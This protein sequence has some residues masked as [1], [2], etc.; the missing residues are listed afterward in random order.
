[1]KVYFFINQ[2][3]QVRLI[4]IYFYEIFKGA[5]LKDDP[6]VVVFGDR[7]VYNHPVDDETPN[8][9][10]EKIGFFENLTGKSRRFLNSL[11]GRNGETEREESEMGLTVRNE[12]KKAFDSIS[13]AWQ[14]NVDRLQ[15]WS[16]QLHGKN[17]TVWDSMASNLKDM[18]GDLMGIWDSSVRFVSLEN[19]TR[20][21]LEG[22]L[23]DEDR[24][25]RLKE[26]IQERSKRVTQMMS[27]V[28]SK[29]NEKDENGSISWMPKFNLSHVDDFVIDM[30][31]KMN[32]AWKKL[33][34]QMTNR[35]ANITT[36][37][38]DFMKNEVER[39]KRIQRDA[40]QMWNTLTQARL[41]NGTQPDN[42][43]MT[44]LNNLRNYYSE[45]GNG[46][47]VDGMIKSAQ[48]RVKKVGEYLKSA[49]EG[50]QDH[51]KSQ[52]DKIEQLVNGLSRSFG[53]ILER[54][55]NRRKDG[56]NTEIIQPTDSSVAKSGSE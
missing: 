34:N 46:S 14:S 39:L 1:M 47:A 42:R 36:E 26:Y 55:M 31:S 6:E 30:Q 10:E 51:V 21:P 3:L 41:E 25:E 50:S 8:R 28:Y 48:E 12:M 5:S 23:I 44:A 32:G 27:D 37:L 22:E 4:N 29:L 45:R 43:F 40:D 11:L 18:R 38:P 33:A 24:A 2:F 17:N 53:S 9:N 7:E 15:G 52:R 35:T 20:T 49:F 56:G 19:K 16:S 54:F 13:S